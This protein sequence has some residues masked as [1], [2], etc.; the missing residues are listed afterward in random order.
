[1]VVRLVKDELTLDS[2]GQKFAII[3]NNLVNLQKGRLVISTVLKIW[4]T[5]AFKRVD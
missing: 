5:I 3:Y 1:M 2:T 4:V